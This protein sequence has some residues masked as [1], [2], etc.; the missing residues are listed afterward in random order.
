M[1]VRPRGRAHDHRVLFLLKTKFLKKI[2]KI[3]LH[4]GTNSKEKYLKLTKFNELYKRVK[5]EFEKNN[6]E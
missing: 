1:E 4:Y 6:N 3:S 5:N 2:K